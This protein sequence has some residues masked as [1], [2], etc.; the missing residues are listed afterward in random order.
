MATKSWWAELVWLLFCVAVATAYT[1]KETDRLSSKSVILRD[2]SMKQEG[3]QTFPFK[4][5]KRH[6]RNVNPRDAADCSIQDIYK[7]RLRDR[8]KSSFKF[9]NETNYNVALTWAGEFNEVILLLTTFEFGMYVGPSHLWRSDNH[10]ASFVSITDKIEKAYIKSRDGL[11]KSPISSQFVILVS[12]PDDILKSQTSKI[13]ITEDAGVHWSGVQLPFEIE[14]AFVFHPMQDSWLLAK[15]SV[16]QNNKLWVSKDFGKSW[17]A[18]HANVWECKWGTRLGDEE[19]IYFTE[20][21]D[22]T[23]KGDTYNFVRAKNFGAEYKTIAEDVFT[24]GVEG[25]FVF[26]SIEV[27]KDSHE[28]L[29]HVSSDGGD[30]WNEAQLPSIT[31]DRFYSILDMSEGMIFMHVDNPEDT[32][33]GTLFTSDADGIVFSQS[34]ERHLYTNFESVSD[35]YKVQSLR[36]VYIASQINADN[37]IRSMITFDRGGVWQPINK[38]AGINCKE[39]EKECSLNIHYKYSQSKGINVPS[40]PLSVP[41]AVGIILAHGHVADAL[42]TTPPDVYVSDDGGYSWSKALDGPHH[43]AITDHGGLLVA[44]SAATDTADTLKFSYDEGQCWHDFK[45]SDEPIRFTGLL[46]EPDSKSLRV[47]LWGFGLQDKE[48]RVFVVDFGELLDSQCNDIDYEKWTAH[49]YNGKSGCLLGQK[50]VFRRLKKTS[51]CRNGYKYEIRQETTECLC[52][53]DDYE[54]DYGY[55]R[56]LGVDECVENPNFK[57]KPLE[58]CIDGE[59]EDIITTGYR[60][61]PGDKCKDGYK[62]ERKLKDDKKKC[63]KTETA[64]KVDTKKGGGH[65]AAIVIILLLV[66]ASSG[67]ALFFLRKNKCF[68]KH[69]DVYKYSVLSKNDELD[70]ALDNLVDGTNITSYHDDSDEDMLE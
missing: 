16:A 33:H 42:Q 37:S 34:L 11:V 54:C 65:T 47:S 63:Q 70:N 35:F 17:M 51:M 25:H 53:K 10:G 9:H 23:K 41:N 4:A 7:D 3:R 64:A 8:G 32:G 30:T 68:R 40:G 39:T 5:K 19:T 26:A 27:N 24:F 2:H 62:P 38:P 46:A 1:R 14:G 56:P 22:P 55:Y 66:I 6:V 67:V 61:I 69:K 45:F 48:W 44:V 49:E 58:V 29:M 57:G 20:D 52:D 13:Y 18:L 60:L 50:E 28:R 31:T 12:Y 43:Y 36:G 21:P 15:S 59:E